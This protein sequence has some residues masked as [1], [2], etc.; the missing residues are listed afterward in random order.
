MSQVSVRLFAAAAEAFGDSSTE[1][2]GVTDL[3]GLV[4]RLSEAR[5]GKLPAILVQ[6]SFFVNGEHRTSLQDPVPDGCRVDVLPP[7][8]GG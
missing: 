3:A 5:P 2:T 7:F 6:C 4:D 1:V 8:A